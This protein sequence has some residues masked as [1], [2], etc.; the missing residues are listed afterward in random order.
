[1]SAKTCFFCKK[2]DTKVPFGGMYSSLAGKKCLFFDLFSHSPIKSP[3]SRDILP[4]TN[5]SEEYIK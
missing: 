4:L 1:M 3:V 2:K 5:C